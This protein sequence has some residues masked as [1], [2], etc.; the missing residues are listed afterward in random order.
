[1]DETAGESEKF[2]ESLVF[3][4][5]SAVPMAKSD[6]SASAYE[7]DAALEQKCPDLTAIASSPAPRGCNV[8]RLISEEPPKN[9]GRVA[10]QTN[11]G[12][13][14]RTNSRPRLSALNGQGCLA[15]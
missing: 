6:S 9:Q 2:Y 11:D 4:Q 12:Q 10:E 15:A 5:A 13:F 14:L 8:R 7:L 3:F 1:M